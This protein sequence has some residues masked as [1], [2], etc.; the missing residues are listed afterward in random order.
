M[1]MHSC[2]FKISIVN[3]NMTVV[4]NLRN[5]E[6]E[7]ALYAFLNDRQYDYE[8]TGDDIKLTFEQENEIIRRDKAFSEGKTTARNW[9]EIKQELERVYR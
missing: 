5:N 8:T 3:L 9:D 1:E 6:E 7:K 4:V 2:N